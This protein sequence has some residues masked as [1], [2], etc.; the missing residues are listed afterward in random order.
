MADK[1]ERTTTCRQCGKTIV[2]QLGA[3]FYAMDHIVC[4]RECKQKLIQAYM[5]E[6]RRQLE[7]PEAKDDK[8]NKLF[9]E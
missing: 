8:Q 6:T 9:G 4:S 5:D 1:T 2:I 7:L 3:I